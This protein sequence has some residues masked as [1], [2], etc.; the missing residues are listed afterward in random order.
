[1]P[2]WESWEE[3]RALF[4]EAR[5]G[6]SGPENC[7]RFKCRWQLSPHHPQANCSCP[8]VPRGA[9]APCL[10]PHSS[11]ISQRRDGADGGGENLGSA[12]ALMSRDSWWPGA[13]EA[14][15]GT[16]SG[17]VRRGGDLASSCS[18]L[19]SE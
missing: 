5:G 13:W 4:P 7:S 2:P 10:C 17:S 11:L 6:A 18:S 16:L 1:M 3:H 19:P 15:L 9:G 12:G 14:S 8:E